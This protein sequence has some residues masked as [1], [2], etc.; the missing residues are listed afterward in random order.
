M[1]VSYDQGKKTEKQVKLHG[2]EHIRG[3]TSHHFTFLVRGMLGTPTL[4]VN[5]CQVRSVSAFYVPNIP[6]L[7]L[8]YFP[9]IYVNYNIKP[10]QSISS[11]RNACHTC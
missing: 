4:G 3:L 2:D 9:I 7:F 8:I 6:L 1:C 10:C 11:H 5:R